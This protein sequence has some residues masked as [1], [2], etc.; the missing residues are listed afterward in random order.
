[1][2]ALLLTATSAVLAAQIPAPVRPAT[3]PITRR[4]DSIAVIGDSS[5]ALAFLDSALRTQPTNAAAWHQFGMLHWAMAASGRRGGYIDDTRVINLLRGA[6][7]ALRLA[8]KFAPD[9]AQYWVTLGRFNL[10]SDVASMHF[11]A[12]RQME[13]AYKAATRIN[14]SLFMAMGADEIGSAIWRRYETTVNLAMPVNGGHVQLQTNARWRRGLAKD[15]LET[16]A[17]KIEPPTG[18]ADYTAA[19]A[20]FREAEA[21][22]PTNLRYSRHLFMALAERARWAELLT[23]ANARAARSPFDAQAR[24]AAGLALHRLGRD[25]QATAVFDSAMSMMDPVDRASLFRLTRVVPPVANALTG[26]R[27]GD[28]ASMTMAS[29]AQGDVLNQ[30]YWLLSD[31]QIGRAHV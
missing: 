12:S 18:T 24:F 29:L 22:G 14:D 2:S 6:D 16:F 4:A 23:T 1:M 3:D 7:S 17:K 21:I 13:N 27:A 30:L 5:R 9:S 20:R 15:F 28:S 25:A 31:P 11:A 8:T 10:Q 19:L 26:N